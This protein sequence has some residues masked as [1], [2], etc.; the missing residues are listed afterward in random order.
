[1]KFL[2]TTS[3]LLPF[4]IGIAILQGI[5]CASAQCSYIGVAAGDSYDFTINGSNTFGSLQ[6]TISGTMHV[7]I[8]NVTNGNP[9]TVGVTVTPPNLNL[10]MLEYNIPIDLRNETF[11]VYNSSLNFYPN[12]VIS[13][14]MLNKTYHQKSSTLGFGGSYVMNSDVSITWDSNGVLSS[15]KGNVHEEYGDSNENLQIDLERVGGSTP[16]P[17]PFTY[18]IVFVAGIA[19]IILKKKGCL[20][21]QVPTPE[22]M[23]NKDR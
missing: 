3:K 5:T 19:I 1:M 13:K 10:I 8:D 9:C 4:L 7:H 16:G 12:L 15:L 17:E 23:G 6:E 14:N 11:L 2:K 22:K 20:V 21:Y 18:A